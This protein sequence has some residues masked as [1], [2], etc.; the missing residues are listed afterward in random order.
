MMPGQLQ[1]TLTS[2]RLSLMIG[3]LGA[4]ASTRSH[5]LSLMPNQLPSKAVGSSQLRSPIGAKRSSSMLSVHQTSPEVGFYHCALE[6]LLHVMFEAVDTFFKHLRLIFVNLKVFLWCYFFSLS[7]FCNFKIEKLFKFP[8]FVILLSLT[9][10]LIKY[11]A[12]VLSQFF[13]CL[14]FT[15]TGNVRAS[16]FVIGQSQNYT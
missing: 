9:Y 14:F 3:H 4:A 7:T 11:P 13:V 12:S 8:I 15:S 10:K 2:H 5:R 1:D 6:Y 16:F